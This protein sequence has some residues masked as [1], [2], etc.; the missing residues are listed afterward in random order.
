MSNIVL[1]IFFVLLAL[2][3]FVFAPDAPNMFSYKS[4]Q[5]FRS[6]KIWK[7][8]N[9]FFGK[10]LFIGSVLFLIISI[11]VEIFDVDNVK[12]DRYML[13]IFA[14]YLC[15]CFVITEVSIYLRINKEKKNG[16]QNPTKH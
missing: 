15:I 16:L 14:S 5:W 12:L 4:I 3:L 10:L 7:W 13:G 9:R 8:A 6:K 11:G 2:Y 1:A